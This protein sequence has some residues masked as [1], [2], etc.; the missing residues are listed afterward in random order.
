M[1]TLYWYGGTGNWSSATGHWSTNSGNSPAADHVAPTSADD[2][3]FDT[4][5]NA[6]AYTCTVDAT[7]NCASITLANPASGNLTFAGSSTLNVYGNFTV[8]SSITRSFTG[9]INFVSTSTGKTVTTNGIS[10]VSAVNFNGV[11]GGWTLQDNFN[12][13]AGGGNITLTAGSLDLNNKTVTC[14]TFSVSGSTVRTLNFGSA[15]I[16]CSNWTATTITNLTL[17]Y[18]TGLITANAVGSCIFAGGGA[19][20]YNVDWSPS[21]TNLSYPNNTI[22]GSNTFNNLILNKA[23]N[24]LK[25]WT[26]IIYANQTINGT[27]YINGN[28]AIDRVFIV[29][30]TQGIARTLTASNT[31]IT[32]ADFRDITGAGAGSW[33]LSAITGGSGD[34]G[35]NSGIVFTT[36]SNQTWNGT[37]GGNWSSNAWT[38]RVPLPQ[39]TAL[40]NKAF[41]SGQ[42]ILLDMP[43]A[44]SI[45]FTGATWT[46]SLTFNSSSY[47]VSFYGNIKFI[48][49]MTLSGNT[50]YYYCGRGNIT[51]DFGNNAQPGNFLLYSRSGTYT[52]NNNINLSGYFDVDLGVTLNA[53]SYNITATQMFVSNPTI[54]STINMGS[55]I[56]TSTTTGNAWFAGSNHVI[57]CQTS[58]IKITN[59][60]NT[61]ITFAGGGK[62]YYNLWFA[63]GSSTA[64]NTITGTNTFADIKDTGTAAHTIVFPNVTTT[65]TSWSINGT[66]GNLISCTRTGASGTWTISDTTGTNNASYLNISNSTATGG[67]TWNA[68]NSTNGGGNTGW[69]F[70]GAPTVYSGY[71][72]FFL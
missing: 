67:A 30:D 14:N 55:G 57:N 50:Q 23:A 63:R 52:L 42:I 71:Y 35:G 36:P 69:N 29:S 8:A 37:S 5:S 27:L 11:G 62:T 40:F 1:A 34:C 3:I 38:T 13:T 45:D 17:N 20:Y 33:N 68:S 65:C 70:G 39:D 24:S 54:T 28:S 51:L 6:T 9:A 7:A 19:T 66:A 44:C 48:S 16:L 59:T 64:T 26:F 10:F 43:R 25:E 21:G 53:G 31:S 49:G 61:N 4:A 56:W 60:T 15:N 2:V 46:T 72:K 32:N 58:T 22:T 18:G 47:N 41:G 12:N